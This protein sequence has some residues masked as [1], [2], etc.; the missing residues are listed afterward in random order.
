VPDYR[1]LTDDE[2]LH[3]AEQRDQL[4]DDAQFALNAELSSRKL[5]SGDIDTYR[6]GREDAEKADELRRART[7]YHYNRGWKK[8]LGKTNRR[9]DE[10]GTFEEYEST[11]WFVVWLFP[12]FPIGT[13]TVRRNIKRRFG[14]EWKGSEVALERHPRDWNQIL[15]TLVKAFLVL[16]TLRLFFLLGRHPEWLKHI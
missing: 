12:V 7:S 9:R 5:S 3:I 13:F 10:S 6:T 15:L 2:L 1:H 4:T 8:F 14:L 16:L 11:L